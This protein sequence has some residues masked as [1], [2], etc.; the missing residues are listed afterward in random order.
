MTRYETS[1][2]HKNTQ[3]G[4]LYNMYGIITLQSAVSFLCT[5][6]ICEPFLNI[7]LCQK[8]KLNL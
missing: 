1:H 3:T 2:K 4:K 7:E 8:N 6:K 5:S